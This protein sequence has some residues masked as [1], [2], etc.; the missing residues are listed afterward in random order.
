MSMRRPGYISL[1]AMLIGGGSLL[2]GETASVHLR[3]GAEIRGDLLDRNT[4]R[5][6]VDLG[7]SV[8]S[9]PSEE[10]LEIDLGDDVEPGETSSPDGLFRLG[11]GMRPA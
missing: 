5:V 11:S 10:V 1:L 8:L 9:I 7:Y 2:T 3:S 4:D 6:V